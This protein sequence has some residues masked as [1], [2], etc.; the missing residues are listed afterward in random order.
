MGGQPRTDGRRGAGQDVDHAAGDVGGRED[1]G[2]RH[3]GQRALV[4]RH[5]DHRVAGDDRGGDHAHQPEERRLLRREERDDA[6]GLAPIPPLTRL[7]QTRASLPTPK[8]GWN[9]ATQTL[10]SIERIPLE[11]LKE[12][13]QASEIGD[14]QRAQVQ[15]QP[16]P[17]DD[18][19]TETDAHGVTRTHKQAGWNKGESRFE[20]QGIWTRAITRHKIV[21]LTKNKQPKDDRDFPAT[22]DSGDQGR[23]VKDVTD[24]RAKGAIVLIPD[25]LSAKE[26][27]GVDV[28]L[29]LHG[30]G[31]GFRERKVARFEKGKGKGEKRVRQKENGKWV[32]LPFHEV[33]GMEAGTVRDVDVDRMEEQVGNRHQGKRSP[34]GCRDAARRVQWR[35][36]PV[37]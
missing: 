5:H 30:Q 22:H 8:G 21:G 37:W 18:T 4:R 9:A 36:R 24:E 28:L 10:G 33:E 35:E 1:L 15:R 3:G 14:V 12:G 25:P 17:S 31:I 2:E 34:D 26:A 6:G 19:V 23:K 11:G 13:S 7:R 16:D 27:E 29:Y 20:K 32:I